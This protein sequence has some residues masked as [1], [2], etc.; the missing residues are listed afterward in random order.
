VPSLSFLLLCA[1]RFRF[2]GAP[3]RDTR[4][5]RSPADREVAR[6]PPATTSNTRCARRFLFQP[7]SRSL[8]H[9]ST[10]RRALPLLDPFLARHPLF[11]RLPPFSLHFITCSREN[12]RMRTFLN[13]VTEAFHG[14]SNPSFTKRFSNLD[15]A[16]TRPKYSSRYLPHLSGLITLVGRLNGEFPSASSAS[17][18]LL[19]VIHRRLGNLRRE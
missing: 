5:R 10:C 3:K 4:R 16:N 8:T 1:R 11:S 15:E 19:H 2:E 14:V 18:Q 17:F 12:E 13:A 9:S 6:L 7:L